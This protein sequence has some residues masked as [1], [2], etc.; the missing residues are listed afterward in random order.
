LREIRPHHWV[1]CWRAE[2]IE[3][4]LKELSISQVEGIF[5]LDREAQL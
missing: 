3:Q 4:E 1:R 2:E 5:K